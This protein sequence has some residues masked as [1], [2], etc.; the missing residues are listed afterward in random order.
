MAPISFFQF[1]DHRFVQQKT[2]TAN[3]TFN[4]NH[5][6]FSRLMRTDMLSGKE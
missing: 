3:V 6:A 2:S 1:E 5:L 4:H